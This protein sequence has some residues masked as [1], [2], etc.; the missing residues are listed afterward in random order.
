[1]KRNNRIINFVKFRIRLIKNNLKYRMIYL[2]NGK[3]ITKDIEGSLMKI[4]KKDKGLSYDLIVDGVR[5]PQ[6]TRLIQKLV[7][8]DDIVIDIGA[9][10][11]YYTLLMKKAKK[12]Y[13]KYLLIID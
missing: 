7:N 4:R 6:S 3:Y 1:M 11:G 13:G 10:I 8:K 12:L 2:R 9:N 5:E